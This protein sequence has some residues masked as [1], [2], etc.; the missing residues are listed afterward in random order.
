MKCLV[1]YLLIFLACNVAILQ[2]VGQVDRQVWKNQTLQ[3]WIRV[4]T[5]KLDI[6]IIIKVIIPS[7]SPS[8]SLTG[9]KMASAT[10]CDLLILQPSTSTSG[11]PSGSPSLVHSDIPSV[12]PSASASASLPGSEMSSAIPSDLP[13]LQPSDSPSGTPSGT[14]IRSKRGS[15]FEP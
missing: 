2:V 12:D 9:S 10:P 6:N 5:N 3:L 7:S 4:Q 8:P 1:Q 11:T 13:S 14:F 15:E